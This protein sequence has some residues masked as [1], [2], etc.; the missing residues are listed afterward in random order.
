MAKLGFT[1]LVCGS[2]HD[3]GGTIDQ[4]FV[5][6][7][8]KEKVTIRKIRVSFSDHDQIRIIVKKLEEN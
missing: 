2:T 3:K 5:N 6:S 1:Q 8:L 4:V 7:D